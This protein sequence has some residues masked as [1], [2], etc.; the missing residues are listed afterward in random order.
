MKRL[1]RIAIVLLACAGAGLFYLKNTA[2]VTGWLMVFNQNS[3]Q[4][5]MG[6]LN[7][8]ENAALMAV[9]LSAFQAFAMPWKKVPRIAIAS[10]A[11]LG[12]V[13]ALLLCLLGRLIAISLWYA[14]GRLLFGFKFKFN[15][16]ASFAYGAV[17]CLLPAWAAPAALLAGSVS[18][19]FGCCIGLAAIAQLFSLGFYAKF[20]NI[21]SSIIPAWCGNFMYGLAAVMLVLGVVLFI[22]RKSVV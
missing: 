2:T 14:I 8:A 21:Y 12:F 3:T 22:D 7:K 13:P 20:A 10:S 4:S 19:P 6:V 16:E 11:V 18:A 1:L 17:A 15:K 9:F 5:I